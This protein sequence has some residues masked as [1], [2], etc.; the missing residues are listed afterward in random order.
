MNITL[1]AKFEKRI[2]EKVA[3]GL[4]TSA[5]EVIRDGL[6]LLFEKDLVKHQQLEVLRQEVSRGVGQLT[7]GEASSKNVLDIFTEVEQSING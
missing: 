7:A 1:G 6:R 2:N 4:Y 5:S 3:S